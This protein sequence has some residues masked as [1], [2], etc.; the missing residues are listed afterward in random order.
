[1]GDSKP[2]A[3]VFVGQVMVSSTFTDL[4]EHRAAAIRAIHKRG[5]R[6]NVMEYDDAKPA[7]DV[8]DSSWQMVRESAGYICLISHKYGQIPECPERNPDRLSL[9]ELEFN[10]AQKLKRPTLLFIMGDEHPVTKKDIESDPEKKKK[11]DAF[12]ERAKRAANSLVNRVYSEFNSLEEF[13]EKISSSLP[14]LVALIVKAPVDPG[15][16]TG[17]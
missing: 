17:K 10:E 5:L 9:T 13:T 12:R 16:A 3:P 2:Y 7:G 15:T 1:M 8:V 6:A 14:A 4:I 11:L